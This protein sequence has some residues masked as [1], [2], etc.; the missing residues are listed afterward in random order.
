MFSSTFISSNTKH[1]F[2]HYECEILKMNKVL[3]PTE[4]I[5]SPLKSKINKHRHLNKSV[6]MGKYSKI[7]KH[8]AYVYS[9]V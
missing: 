7:D 1:S 4:F 3:A 5:L 9:E 2:N 8:R 6:G